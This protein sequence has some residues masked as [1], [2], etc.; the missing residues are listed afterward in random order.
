MTYESFTLGEQ[1]EDE[2]DF[3]LEA[4]IMMTSDEEE[5]VVDSS[6]M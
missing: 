1:S 2:D 6:K 5:E 3:D 4:I